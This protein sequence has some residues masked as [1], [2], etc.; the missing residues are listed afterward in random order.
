MNSVIPTG[1]LSEYLSLCGAGQSV[2][3]KP[4][5]AQAFA[6]TLALHERGFFTWSEWTQALGCAIKE[7][8]AGGDPDTG[9]TYYSHW[10][11]ALEQILAA[12]HLVGTDVLVRHQQALLRAARRTPHGSPVEVTPFDLED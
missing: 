7:A 2:F 12:K 3:A 10:L 6:M 11:R 4:W 5:E 1:E 8:Q 9:K